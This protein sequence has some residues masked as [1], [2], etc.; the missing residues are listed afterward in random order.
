MKNFK[1]VLAAALVASMLFSL[2]ACGK[3]VV[4]IDEDD[5]SDALE[6][7]IDWEEG[8]EFGIIKDTTVIATTYDEAD[9]YEYDADIYINGMDYGLTDYSVYVQYVIF[10]DED[11]ANDY[12]YCYYEAYAE[13]NK[14][15]SKKYTE[16]E[17]GYFI[18]VN[19]DDGFHA[20]YYAEDMVFEIRAFDEASAKAVRGMLNDFGFPTK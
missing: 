2:T 11:D 18:D 6:D 5:F 7:T 4:K 9:S 10:D 12:F 1:K 14:D 13:D 8:R 20:F 3:K 17:S 19:V 15:V 16:G